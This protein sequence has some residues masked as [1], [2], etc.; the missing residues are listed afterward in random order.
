MSST[1]YTELELRK[2]KGQAL[3]DV[4]HAMI[5]K[6]AGVKNTTGLKNS[7]E[8]LQAILKGQANPEFL[9][10]FK[11]KR[12]IHKAE[13]TPKVEEMPEEK[14]KRGPKPKPKVVV[15]PPPQTISPQAVESKEKP[16]EVSDVIRYSFYTLHFNDHQYYVDRQT[17]SIFENIQGK[18][19]KVLGIWNSETKQITPQP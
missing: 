19:G 6:E 9:E 4:W 2:L 17:K 3:K 5:G 1:L 15:P 10:P 16:C 12:Q 11:V 13:E 8:I 7:E 18:P 14:K